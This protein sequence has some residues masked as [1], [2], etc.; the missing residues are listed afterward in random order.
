MNNT[1]LENNNNTDTDTSTTELVTCDNCDKEFNK[2]NAEFVNG[3]AICTDCYR[4]EYSICD[5]C[6]S[7][8]HNNDLHEAYRNRQKRLV[9]NECLQ[10]NYSECYDCSHYFHSENIAE[11]NGCGRLFCEDCVSYCGDCDTSYCDGCHCSCGDDSFYSNQEYKEVEPS[12]QAGIY[13]INR[14]VGCEIEVENTNRNASYLNNLVPEV[15]GLT[16]DG[17]LENGC[18]IITP[19]LKGEQLENILKDTVKGISEAGLI[20]QKSCGLHIHLNAKDLKDKDILHVIQTYYRI[21][22]IFYNMLPRSRSNSNFC[23]RLDS[24]DIE[25]YKGS[26][27]TKLKW[28]GLDK[29]NIHKMYNIEP[30]EYKEF[31]KNQLY[32]CTHEKYNHT[33]YFGCNI[34]SIYYRGTL[35][36]RYHSG[37]L[38]Y[39]KIINWIR[40]HNL[41]LDWILTKFN[42]KDIK[43]IKD[44]TNKYEKIGIFCKTFSIPSDLQAYITERTSTFDS[45]R[46]DSLENSEVN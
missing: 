37:T 20:V 39:T 9:C 32:R 3:M 33:R 7:L 46:V 18:E 11:C 22:D 26:K 21:E 13:N 40:L 27:D 17:S 44:T 10:E 6:E 24:R 30:S 14:L 4:Y 34:H 8:E 43:A 28:Y 35:E 1:V 16:R 38:N 25:A 42:Y 19:P 2:D 41:I 31:S 15:V 23:K 36:I 12:E 5:D 29:D 45:S